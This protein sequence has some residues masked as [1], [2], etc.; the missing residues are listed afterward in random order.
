MA[1]TVLMNDSVVLGVFPNIILTS[2][3]KRLCFINLSIGS[4]FILN[5]RPDKYA[6]SGNVLMI[7]D[8]SQTMVSQIEILMSNNVVYKLIPST[9]TV[10]ENKL[11][12]IPSETIIGNKALLNTLYLVTLVLDPIS[13][14]PAFFYPELNGVRCH[15]FSDGVLSINDIRGV[16]RQLK[17]FNKI[18]ILSNDFF[19]HDLLNLPDLRDFWLETI[20][21]YQYYISHFDEIANVRRQ[22]NVIVYIKDILLFDD[23]EFSCLNNDN[24]TVECYCPVH[25]IHELN[26]VNNIRVK[27]NPCPSTA[28]S[29]LLIHSFLDYSEDDLN[30]TKVTRIQLFLN[31]VV[32]TNYYGNVIIDNDGNIN[33]YPFEKYLVNNHC[34]IGQVITEIKQNSYWFLTREKFFKKCSD[35]VFSAICP[36]LSNYEI[37]FKETFCPY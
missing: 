12:S 33:S 10:L 13:E 25:N 21:E 36:P 27:V 26:V 34:R 19:S 16:I 30:K 23:N 31:K 22:L 6:L 20:V 4:F 37:N 1:N 32:N 17:G 9:L 11:H 8:T 28:I 7:G 2:D 3:S 24:V 5:I 15:K 14:L 18:R 29:K 35:C